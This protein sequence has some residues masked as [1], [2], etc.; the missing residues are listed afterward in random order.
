MAPTYL[1]EILQRHRQ[2]AAADTRNWR[3]RV[4]AVR[5]NEPTHKSH[6]GSEA[7]LAEPGLAE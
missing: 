7:T 2:R 5:Y 6:R 4:G 3:E 1:D